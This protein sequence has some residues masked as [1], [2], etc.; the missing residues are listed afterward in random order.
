MAISIFGYDSYFLQKNICKHIKKMIHIDVKSTKT[1][2]LNR[3]DCFPLELGIDTF[4]MMNN[5][6]KVKL[7]AKFVNCFFFILGNYATIS[8]HFPCRSFSRDHF[9]TCTLLLHIEK[10]K[11]KIMAQRPK[12]VDLPV[13]LIVALAQVGSVNPRSVKSVRFAT[14]TTFLRSCVAQTLSKKIK[15]S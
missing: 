4:K 15:P 2:P 3:L 9:Y 10:K 1:N 8:E 11:K 7:A 5:R 6:R 12:V 14:A 13:F